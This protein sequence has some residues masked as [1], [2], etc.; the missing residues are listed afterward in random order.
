MPT[1]IERF[2]STEDSS[3]IAR[4]YSGLLLLWQQD[5]TSAKAVSI[6]FMA[7]VSTFVIHMLGRDASAT[8]QD[9]MHATNVSLKFLWLFLEKKG[10]LSVGED[11][12]MVQ[13]A[14]LNF[15]NLGL[16]LTKCVSTRNERYKFAQLIAENEIMSLAGRVLLS[17][18][19]QATSESAFQ[20]EG[21]PHPTLQQLIG[22]KD[23]FAAA[24]SIAPELF[25]DSG[26]EWSK[27]GLAHIGSLVYMG[28][29]DL[30]NSERNGLGRYVSS[31]LD[32]WAHYGNYFRHSTPVK[33]CSYPQCFDSAIPRGVLKPQYMCGKCQTAVYCDINCQ[34]AHWE[35]A[36]SEAHKLACNRPGDKALLP[37]GKG[38]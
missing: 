4:A 38:S 34:R 11:F 22:L 15:M 36:T 7:D 5:D 9:L 37:Q 6:G 23:V 29:I 1:N 21:W 19:A 13:Y 10:Q 25:Y 2:V 20:S 18:I 35:L 27:V 17:T 31:M 28:S 3:S 32:T 12:G 14:G 26:I 16:I 24:T 33:A 30:K 8:T